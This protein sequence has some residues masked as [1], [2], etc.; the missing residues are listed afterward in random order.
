[1]A[2][3]EKSFRKEFTSHGIVVSNDAE[4]VKKACAWTKIHAKKISEN[5]YQV[6]GEYT[7]YDAGW[8]AQHFLDMIKEVA[9]GYIV[10]SY[11]RHVAG[12]QVAWIER[13]D[14]YA[15]VD[16]HALD[17]PDDGLDCEALY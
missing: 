4:A 7:E 10:T 11:A 16:W 2:E 3:T 6:Y 12:V 9:E 5:T 15:Y 14:D 13:S 1:M 8:Q 17:E